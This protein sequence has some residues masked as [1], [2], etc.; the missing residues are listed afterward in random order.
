M[1]KRHFKVKESNLNKSIEIKYQLGVSLN[2]CPK[3]KN[4]RQGY[5]FVFFKIIVSV[6]IFKVFNSFTQIQECAQAK[7]LTGQ[8]IITNETGKG[9]TGDN[10][11]GNS[12]HTAKNT[13]G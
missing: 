3:N 5:H 2:F 6:S 11:S 9:F 7:E 4:Y 10:C 13:A 1:N 8:T 12:I